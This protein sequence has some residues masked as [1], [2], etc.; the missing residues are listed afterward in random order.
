MAVDQLN[1][2]DVRHA[3][4]ACAVVRR[5]L[6]GAEWRATCQGRTRLGEPIEAAVKMI[7]ALTEE[8]GGVGRIRVA[9][10]LLVVTVYRGTGK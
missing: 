7:D 5:E 1:A 3:L 6:H 8:V 9:A 4:K 10:K 2:V